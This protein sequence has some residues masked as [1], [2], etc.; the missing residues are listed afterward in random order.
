[1][2]RSP[3]PILSLFRVRRR[4]RTAL[5]S[6]IGLLFLFV[7]VFD[8][9]SPSEKSI[10]DTKRDEILNRTRSRPVLEDRSKPRRPVSRVIRQIESIA[11]TVEHSGIH[12]YDENGLLSVDPHGPHP[13]FELIQ[14]AEE[15]WA[16]KHRQASR[17]LGQAVKEYRR[18]YGREPPA[19]FDL[20]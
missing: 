16:E 17:T 2:A 7:F 18:R 14:K 20:W 11:P 5:L 15:R 3:L 19:G 9:G 6:F 4:S 12:R 1:M 8:F 10:K 13:I